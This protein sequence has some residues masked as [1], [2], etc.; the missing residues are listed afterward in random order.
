MQK[1]KENKQQDGTYNIMVYD[2]KYDPFQ[3]S[4]FIDPMRSKIVVDTPTKKIKLKLSEL[5]DM[6]VS[7]QIMKTKSEH[8]RTKLFVWI[9]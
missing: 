4:T 6:H 8:L 3:M 9:L 5:H 2:D 1:L 7:L